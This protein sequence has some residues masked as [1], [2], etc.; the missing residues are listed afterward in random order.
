MV[1]WCC[2][3]GSA[4]ACRSVR[5]CCAGV[6]PRACQPFPR[7]FEAVL[8]VVVVHGAGRGVGARRG[9]PRP[10]HGQDHP[11]LEEAVDLGTAGEAVPVTGL[12]DE[13]VEDVGRL[14]GE[15]VLHLADP[16]SG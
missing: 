16:V 3:P 4:A 10:G 8:E 14:V 7:T 1:T 12:E 15:D 6:L 5:A 11:V 2:S 9:E 13:A